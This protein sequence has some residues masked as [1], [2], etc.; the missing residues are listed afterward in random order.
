MRAL[1]IDDIQIGK[2]Y[3]GPELAFGRRAF[4]Q[5]TGVGP[6]VILPSLGKCI[7]RE[8]AKRIALWRSGQRGV[9]AENLGHQPHGYPTQDNRE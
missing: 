8:P 7:R 6:A 1:A 5:K 4:T 2:I 9:F 3:D